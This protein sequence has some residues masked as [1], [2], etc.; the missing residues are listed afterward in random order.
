MN[1]S[2]TDFLDQ[3]DKYYLGEKQALDQLNQFDQFISEKRKNF[4]GYPCNAAFKLDKFFKWWAQSSL[5]KSPLNE[6][7][8]PSSESTYGLNARPFEMT[9]LQF[10]ANLYSIKPH[11]GYITS[12]GTQGNEQ[13]LY[14][15]RQVLEKYG[16][17]IIYFSV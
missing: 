16:H 8:D 5:S 14:I 11:W 10:F 13:G 7:G 2:S 1:A 15:G 4:M 9:V 12:G 17:P 3:Q 6:A